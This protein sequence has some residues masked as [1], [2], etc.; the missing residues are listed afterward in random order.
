MAGRINGR[1][2]SKQ[3]WTG[4]TGL[5]LLLAD[6]SVYPEPGSFLAADREIDPKTGTIRISAAFPNPTHTLRPG[7]YGRVHAETET[8]D[9]A[10]LVPQR[11]V[12]ELQGS[13]QLRLVTPDNHVTTRTVKLGERAGNRWIVAEGVKPGER[14]VVEGAQTRDGA[15]VNPK[16]FTATGEGH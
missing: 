9:D 16:P 13:Y 1:T 3:P 6:G 2:A 4:G 15:V 10:I 8:L 14:V 12:I 7:E 5:T 11:A